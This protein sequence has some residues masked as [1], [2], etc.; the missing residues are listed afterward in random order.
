MKTRLTAAFVKTVKRPGAYCDQHGLRLC[1]RQ[2]S[3]KKLISK[4]WSWR[5]TI[6]GKRRDVG[7]GGFPY[8]TLAE[9]RATAFEYRKLARGGGDPRTLRARSDIPTFAEA[10]EKVIALHAQTWKNGGKSETQWRGS[11]R[12]Y[13]MPQLG[14]KR[15]SEI[16]S[17]DVLAVLVPHWQPKRETMR[18]LRGRISAIMQWAI[19]QNYRAD[20]PAGDAVTAALPRNNHI[21][22]HQ[23]SLP[24]AAVGAAIGKVR[25]SQASLSAKLVIEFLILTAARSGEARGATWDEI[26]TDTATWIVPAERM[27]S[28]RAHRVPLPSRALEILAEARELSDGSGLIFPSARSGALAAA[29]LAKL[30][31]DLGIGGTVHGFRSSFRDWAAEC[32]DAPREVCEMSLAHVEGSAVER[33]YRRTDLFE[34][35]R[36]LM[37]AWATYVAR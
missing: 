16:S 4:Q 18:R 30:L 6:G 2:S 28:K 27:K 20:N 13:A 37:E 35:R 22:T 33:A 10:V 34:R 11:L 8:I 12:D 31:H 1:V 7:L 29:T 3:K 5:G 14:G 25:A 15:V 24:Y 9:A 17:G 23:R 26:D 21:V 32:S 19:A 36:K